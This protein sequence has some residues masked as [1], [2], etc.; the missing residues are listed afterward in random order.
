MTALV[1]FLEL[2]LI[3]FLAKRTDACEN[4]L[5]YFFINLISFNIISIIIKM[6]AAEYCRIKI[7]GKEVFDVVIKIMFTEKNYGLM[8]SNTKFFCFATL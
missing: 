6:F 7:D 4:F 3:S 2:F 5:I 1:M 8:V